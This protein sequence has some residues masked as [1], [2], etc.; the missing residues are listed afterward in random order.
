MFRDKS[1]GS[2]R[3]LIAKTSGEESIGNCRKGHSKVSS[4]FYFDD[5]NKTP[6]DPIKREFRYF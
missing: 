4:S 6:V 1:N 3:S 5:F 2:F